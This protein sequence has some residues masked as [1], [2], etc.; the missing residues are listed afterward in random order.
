MLLTEKVSSIEL[1]THYQYLSSKLLNGRKYNTKG[2]LLAQDYLVEQ[3]QQSNIEP[4]NGKF[5]HSFQH[6]KTIKTIQGTNIV[7][8]LP[9]R[10]HSLNYI[11]LTAHYDHLGTGHLGADDNASGTAALL[12]IAKQL[13]KKV[14]NSN[15][16]FLFTDAEEAGLL[17]AKA[18]ASENPTLMENTLLNVNLDMLAGSR[19]SRK[20]HYVSY[21]INKI[22]SKEELQILKHLRKQQPLPIYKGFKR[23]SG[24]LNEQ[25]TWKTAS[26]HGVFYQRKIPFIY[27]GVGT[28]VNYHT[29]KDTYE[30]SNK[31]LLNQSANAIY[32]HLLYINNA[33]NN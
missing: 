25:V 23:A 30:N 24:V 29:R 20:L 26:D 7:G 31:T 3:L 14:L 9:S 10:T 13:S 11:V 27:Y 16:V 15:I 12:A 6:E 8:L 17:G 18:F 4:F 19:Y 21:G 22:L 28:H 32:Q 2:S 33:I 1:D 5:R